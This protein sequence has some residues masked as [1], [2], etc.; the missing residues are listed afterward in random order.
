MCLK[1]GCLIE[2][3]TAGFEFAI[4]LVNYVR[5]DS[6]VDTAG[7]SSMADCTSNNNANSITVDVQ[8]KSTSY[9][10]RSALSRVIPI[11]TP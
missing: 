9:Y 4:H 10:G 2:S 8:L 6:S 7:K 5:C 1:I 11:W 3:V